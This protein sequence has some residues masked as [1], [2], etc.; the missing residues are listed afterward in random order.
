MARPQTKFTFRIGTADHWE[1]FEQAIAHEASRLCGG[2]TTSH[3]VGWWAEDGT[4]RK[5]TFDGPF[6]AEH[7]FN[8]E[9]TCEFDKA[10][11]VYTQMRA[12]ISALVLRFGVPVHWVHVEETTIRGR[13]F[14]ADPQGRNDAPVSVLDLALAAGA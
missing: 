11:R 8:V 2:C 7:C 9:L 14:D 12:A 5:E 6:E 10:E 13:H 1:H 4:E 3:A